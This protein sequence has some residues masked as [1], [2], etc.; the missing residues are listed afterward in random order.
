M[1]PYPKSRVSGCWGRLCVRGTLIVVLLAGLSGLSPLPYASLPD[2]T[3]I[4][5]IYYGPDYD[6]DGGAVDLPSVAPRFLPHVFGLLASLL[7]PA[8]SQASVLAFH[9]RS[10][11]SA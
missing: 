8:S 3:W 11:P 1:D 10:P 4:P 7:A 5:G 2:P 9:L 6:D